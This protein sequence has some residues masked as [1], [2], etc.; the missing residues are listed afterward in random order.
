MNDGPHLRWLLIDK[1]NY[2]LLFS[3]GVLS[4]FIINN[5]NF[6]KRKFTG[7]WSI[8]IPIYIY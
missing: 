6:F 1:I 7:T 3:K 2:H 4:V 8:D 5:W